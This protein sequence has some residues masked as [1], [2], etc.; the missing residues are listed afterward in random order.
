M[1]SQSK[2]TIRFSILVGTVLAASLCAFLAWSVNA[3]DRFAED[4][5]LTEARMLD[6]SIGSAWDYLD[7]SQ[8]AINY[9][10]DG[11]YDFKHIYCA[12]AGKN[13][14]NRITQQS[15]G[16]IVRYAREE[17]RSGT[18][19]PDSF[20]RD[21]IA[22][23]ENSEDLEYYRVAEYDGKPVLRYASRLDISPNCLEC[24]GSPAGTKDVTGFL[25]EG[26]QVGDIAGVT[27]IVIPLA[28]YRE[29][30]ASRATESLLFFAALTIIVVIAVRLGLK[31]WVERPLKDT[32]NELAEA[33]RAQS[34]FL[35]TMSHELR[36]P[37]SS[38]IAFADIWERESMSHT[39]QERKMVAEVKQNSRALLNMVN[40]TIDT[41]KI[42]AGL[43]ELKIEETDLIDVVD[44]AID[45]VDALA[46]KRKITVERH[47][48]LD[49]PIM[50][51][52]PYAI[53]KILVN[54][55]SNAI[56]FSAEDSTVLIEAGANSTWVTISVI[57]W[58]CGIDPTQKD[59]VFERFKQ[60]ENSHGG[61]GLGLYL[62]RTLAEKLGGSVALESELGCGCTFTVTLPI[63]SIEN[64]I[65]AQDGKR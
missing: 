63:D 35:A 24:H 27:S 1:V 45:V 53:Q 28:E 25:R 62:V 43:F 5:A 22:Q 49:A 54:L 46:R 47:M 39:P 57:D 55:L 41:A 31:R 2:L 8:G 34:D 7:D 48:Q 61:S 42:D 52:D 21:A 20:E 56:R 40:N 38:I 36:T 10:S 15:D 26:M 13:I 33:N 4:K 12:V 6:L 11:S 44:S 16:Y 17:P 19:A 9:N 37:L 50:Q 32:N 14:A 60:T 64:G 65:A 29:E 59:R 23:F 30:A 51:S 3:H 18:D 58:G